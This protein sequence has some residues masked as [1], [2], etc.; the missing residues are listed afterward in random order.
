MPASWKKLS[1]EHTHSLPVFDLLRER[2]VSPRT[3]R[4]LD[5]TIVDC[6]DWVN[7]V[8][9]TDKQE[10]VLVHQF[11]FGT[12]DIT[13]EIPGGMI[14]EGESPAEA[15]ARELREETGYAAT[16]WTSLGSIATNPAFMRNR[17]HAFLAEGAHL[18]G[19]LELDDTED[20]DVET[21]P[22]VD[23][24]PMIASGE[25]THSLVTFAFHRL[26]L[27]RRGHSLG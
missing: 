10:V 7:V 8:A 16:R 1:S 13:I 3:E 26:D 18:V 12:E 20:I 19:E 21:R 22:L 24:D 4:P 25:I 14:D 9:L 5:A 15:A 27:L 23:I 6:C 2:F 17:L 11:R